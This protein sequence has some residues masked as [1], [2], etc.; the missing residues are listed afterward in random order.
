[1]DSQAI[2]IKLNTEWLRKRRLAREQIHR[3]GLRWRFM[4]TYALAIPSSLPLPFVQYTHLQDL[5]NKNTAI[6]WTTPERID[7]GY[8]ERFIYEKWT[9]GNIHTTDLDFFRFFRQSHRHS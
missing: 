2:Q 1:M 3:R 8:M 5:C 9:Q 6:Y 4:G 7:T